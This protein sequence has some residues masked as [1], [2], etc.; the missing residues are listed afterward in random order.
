MDISQILNGKR[1]LLVFCSLEL[2]GAQRQGMHLARY[3]KGMGCDVSVMATNGRTGFFNKECSDAGIPW[4]IQRFHWP[5]R[6]ISLLRDSWA[7][8]RTLRKVRPNVI[9]SYTTWANVGCGLTWRLSPARMCI[10]S[11]RGVN[12]LR[13]D[14]LERFVYRRVS[15]VICNA[16]HEV[17]YLHQTLGETPAPV[18]VVHNGVQLAPCQKTRAEW[19]GELGIEGYSTVATM[20]AN[21]GHYKDHPTLLRAWQKVLKSLPEG[22]TYP[23]LLLAGF[24]NSIP[25]LEVVQRLIIELGIEGSVKILGQVRDVSG[26]LAASD[27]GILASGRVDIISPN[28][29]SPFAQEGLSNSVLEYM[30]SGLP[31]VATDLPGN[32]EALGEN[33]QQPFCKLGDADSLCACLK[34]FLHD[35]N[36]CR[37]LGERNQQRALA[38]FSLES[39]CE[40]T[41][42]IIANLLDGATR[43]M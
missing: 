18:H 7:M 19:R 2:A 17:G 11:Q 41:V 30:A 21:F 10:W 34:V 32:H 22:Q 8:V 15:A 27:I 6:K 43:I 39:M 24:A 4:S 20:V 29:Q 23:R 1:I 42:G 36:L 31:V 5:C 26:L 25:Y 40:K 9:L 14:A 12:S 37:E 16:G 33:P 28:E 13:G 35:P 3:L 38:D